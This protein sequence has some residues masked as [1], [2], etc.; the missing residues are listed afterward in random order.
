M[1]PRETK[2]YDLFEQDVAN[3]VAASKELMD[4][5][6]NYDA[7]D[8]RVARIIDL[9]HRG[10]AITH[11]IMGRLHRTFVTPIDR[12]DIAFLT[13]SLDDIMDFIEGAATTTRIYHIAQPTARAR[14]LA[15]IIPKMTAELAEAIPCLRHPKQFQQIL[16][17]CVEINRLE[18]EADDVLHAALA[19]LFDDNVD[20][21]EVI[22]WREIYE[23]LES[24]TDRGEDVANA[25]EGIVLKHA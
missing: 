7:V 23:Q 1:L 17:H 16:G 18:N 20:I 21:I 9:E 3:L 8:D 19:E 4:L 15:A 10:D 2:F 13:H 24:A 14:E 22:K 5:F 6:Q 12:E 25:L 11:E